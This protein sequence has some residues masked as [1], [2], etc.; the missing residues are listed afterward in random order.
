MNSRPL[1]YNRKAF[2]WGL[3]KKKTSEDRW[4]DNEEKYEYPWEYKEIKRLIESGLAKIPSDLKGASVERIFEKAEDHDKTLF[5]ANIKI[6]GENKVKF[7]KHGS[8]FEVKIEWDMGRAYITKVTCDGDKN[9]AREVA[10]NVSF[11]LENLGLKNFGVGEEP[12]DLLKRVEKEKKKEGKTLESVD[13]EL[14]KAY[15]EYQNRCK[16][17]RKYKEHV[18]LSRDEYARKVYTQR[19]KPSGVPPGYQQIQDIALQQSAM[20]DQK[21]IREEWKELH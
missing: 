5:G 11:Y 10:K 14:E 2:L 17:K 20:E 21:I 4:E 15:R 9:A 12:K 6:K 19:S 7:K 16:T 13:A 8:T 1:L 3:I 18:Q